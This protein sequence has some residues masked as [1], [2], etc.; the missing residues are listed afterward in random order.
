M[1]KAKFKKI[2]DF[3]N[4]AFV[5]FILVIFYFSVIGISF[6]IYRLSILFSSKKQTNSYWID[7]AEKE[8]DIESFNSPF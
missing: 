2:V 4:H 3:L 5:S 1:Q 6:L 7:E 8:A